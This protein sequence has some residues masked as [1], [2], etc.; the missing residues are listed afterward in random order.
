MATTHSPDPGVPQTADKAKIGGLVSAAV[1]AVVLLVAFYFDGKNG[2]TWSKTI[3]S[4]V[5]AVLGGGG[6]ALSVYHKKNK[7]LHKKG[8]VA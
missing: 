4:V 3:L 6:T 1:I 2:T 7:P 5:V 8:H